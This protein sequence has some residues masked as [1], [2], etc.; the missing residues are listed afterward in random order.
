[1]TDAEASEYRTKRNLK[2]AYTLTEI[3]PREK[4]AE[5]TEAKRAE[6]AKATDAENKR[7]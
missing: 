6:V 2:N 5:P 3:Q 1:M 4:A 7:G